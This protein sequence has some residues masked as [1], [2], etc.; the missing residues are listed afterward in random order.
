MLTQLLLHSFTVLY[1]AR[2]VGWYLR[3]PFADFV[4]VPRSRCFEIQLYGDA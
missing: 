3:W 1:S 4:T 2:F